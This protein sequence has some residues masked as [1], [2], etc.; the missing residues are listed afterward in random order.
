MCKPQFT[1]YGLIIKQQLLNEMHCATTAHK[2]LNRRIKHMADNLPVDVTTIPQDLNNSEFS[3]WFF[4][5]SVQFKKFP[6][7]KKYVLNIELFYNELQPIYQEIHS[8]YTKEIKS[9]YLKTLLGLNPSVIT[10]K[11]QQKIQQL[12][13]RFEQLSDSIITA[14]NTLEGHIAIHP[15]EKL[16]VFI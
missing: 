7:L 13:S 1:N 12:F 2:R 5:R 10:K 11:D 3:K 6:E 4:G 15:N 16:L 14:L 9:S 8:T